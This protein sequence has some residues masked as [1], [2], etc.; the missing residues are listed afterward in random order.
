[1]LRFTNNNVIRRDCLGQEFLIINVAYL[2]VSF[3]NVTENPSGL[4]L[5]RAAPEESGVCLTPLDK[6]TRLVR[7]YLNMLITFVSMDS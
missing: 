3:Y 4:R 5:D 6:H 7:R 1:M 2:G